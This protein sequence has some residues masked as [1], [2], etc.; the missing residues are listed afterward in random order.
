[1][2]KKITYRSLSLI[3]AFLVFTSSVS[4][5]IDIHYCGGNAESFNF[6]G[7]AETCHEIK[8]ESKTS[9]D[10][11][12]CKKNDN[13]RSHC[14]MKSKKKDCCHNEKFVFEQDN[15]LKLSDNSTINLEEINPVLVFLLINQ[16]FFEFE[17]KYTFYSNYDPPPLFQ[18]ILVQQQVFRI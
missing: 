13:E 4:F 18:N 10:H 7:E 5:A 1:M 8:Q 15:D 17:T 6:F 14:K 16:H 12:C 9:T 11:E 2:S 3:M